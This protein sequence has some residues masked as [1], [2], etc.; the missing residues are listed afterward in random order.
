MMITLKDKLKGKQFINIKAAFLERSLKEPY[1]QGR[2]TVRFMFF[3]SGGG[4]QD[5][6]SWRSC[7]V[8]SGTRTTYRAGP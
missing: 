7:V 1:G 8:C 3:F 2:N 5:T 4:F 6:V